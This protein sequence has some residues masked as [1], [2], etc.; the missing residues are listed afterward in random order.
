M[1]KHWF[2]AMVAIFFLTLPSAA[3]RYE[4]KLNFDGR[5]LKTTGS[6]ESGTTYVPLRAFFEEIGGYEVSWRDDIKTA[7]VKGEGFE[8][9][10]KNGSNKASLNGQAFYMSS[11]CVIRQGVT[12]I[13]A[14]GIGQALG[15]EVDYISSSRTVVYGSAGSDGAGDSNQAHKDSLQ[16]L[17]QIIHAESWGEPLEG[18]IAVGNVVLNRVKSKDFPNTIYDV[19]FDTKNGV[20]FTPVANGTIYNTPSALS[21]KAAQMALDGHVVVEDCLFFFNP[22]TATNANWIVANKTYHVSI[23]NH[24]FYH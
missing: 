6:I 15:R 7:F 16:W 10:V 11:S 5:I 3:A 4:A 13:P 12:S 9:A 2:A 20:Q 1:K 17:A 21:V 18:Q 24:D 19:I 22:K 8:L 14:R 23:G